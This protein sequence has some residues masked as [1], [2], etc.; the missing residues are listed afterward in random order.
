MKTVLYNGKVYLS[1]EEFTEAVLVEN[2]LIIKT[3]KN[4]D[5]ITQAGVD[6]KKIDC[7][8]KTVIPGLNDSHLHLLMF[9]DSMA[10]V[11]IEDCTS[12]GD[13]IDRC[14]KFM[15][16]QPENVKHGIHALGW[17]QDLFVDKK[18]KSK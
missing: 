17:N 9:G 11:R 14:K 2:G 3:G 16:E 13:M 6:C 12:I 15:K 1:R 4:E 18:E 8:G 10:Q 5:I 7:K